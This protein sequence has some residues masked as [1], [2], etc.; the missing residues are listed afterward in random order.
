[1]ARRIRY[2][3]MSGNL[4]ITS[5]QGVL[6]STSGEPTAQLSLA[7]LPRCLDLGLALQAGGT[8]VLLANNT[9]VAYRVLWGLRDANNNLLYGAPSNRA[10]IQNT[11]GGTRDVDVTI[12]IPSEITTSHFYQVYRTSISTTSAD[13]GDEMSLVFENNPTTAE[14]T[15]AVITY[16]DI[17]PDISR[18]DALYTNASQEGIENA[19]DRPPLARDLCEFRGHMFYAYTTDHHR[20]TVSLIGTGGL[21]VGTSTLTIGGV[22][23][24]CQAAETI[25]SGNFLKVTTGTAAQQIE[26]TAQSLCRVINGYAANTNYNAYYVSTPDTRPGEILVEERGFGG[27]AI[28]ATANSS[29]T[30]NSFSPPIP[31]SGTTYTSTAD[32]RENGIRVSKPDEAEAVP[33]YRNL[34]VGS[35]NDKLQRILA[36]RDSVVVIKDKTIWRITGNAFEE[37]VVTILDNTTSCA[38]RD[39]Y[40]VLNNTVFGLSNQGFIAITDNGVQLVGRPEEH[41]VLALLSKAAAPNHDVYV[42][43]GVEAQR[44]YICAVNDTA[45]ASASRAYVFNAI[46]RTWTT[47]LL[48]AFCIGF[49]G[50]RLVYGHDST[51]GSV[52]RQRDS[53][54]DGDPQYRDF[55][56]TSATFTISS[57]DTAASTATGVLSGANAQDFTPFDTI[58]AGCK[59]YDGAN[60][61]LVTT[62]AS[63]AA[64]A[65]LVLTMHSVSGLTNGAK[66]IYAPIP[67]TVEWQP[68][69]SGDPG[70]MKQYSDVV[71]RSE[72]QNCY[73]ATFDFF[74]NLDTKTNAT[75][76]DWA[77]GTALNLPSTAYIA[78]TG[79]PSSTNHDFGVAPTTNGI[80]ANNVI[81]TN[82]PKERAMGEHLSV[83]LSHSAAEARL[84]V[85]TMTIETRSS[86]STK[87]K[88]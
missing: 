53:L 52:L 27:S 84:G 76:E 24:T 18:G 20:M 29:A 33:T 45:S 87:G 62:G 3:E 82:V 83:R 56:N 59:I 51:G 22:V 60:Q 12:R 41:R 65:S 9:W 88:Q 4:L 80:V 39:S 57:I 2:A 81:E 73:R 69:T 35:R 13:P 85:K 1:M 40:A 58:P 49:S 63:G 61:F 68:R 15:A 54:R 5:A 46:T 55:A 66:T 17:V 79:Q 74:N 7:G 26:G 25:T 64:G 50:D 43:T 44:I 34:F 28:V 47:W 67:V 78:R 36:L 19:N 38:G 21:T 30:G 37:F 77:S 70:V 32:T 72:T 11:A 48:N 6:K 14:L 71:V 42:G 23:Y 8:P 86:E 75:D 10:N 31:T 16:R